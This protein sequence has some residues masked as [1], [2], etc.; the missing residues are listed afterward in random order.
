[1]MGKRILLAFLLLTSGCDIDT[2][3]PLAQF[4]GPA[5]VITGSVT[6][7]SPPPCT[8]NGEIVGAA[9]LFAFEERLLPPPEG[10]GTVPVALSVVS[11]E[12][13]FRSVRS[14]LAFD[15]NGARLCPP[16]G[17]P[18]VTVTA[19]YSLSPL[20]GGVYQIRGFYDYDGDFNPG[21]SM[22][23]LPT[24]GDV[25]GGAI[26]NPE[27]VLM[28]AAPRFRGVPLGD[29]DPDGVRRIPESG[30]L[31]E[32][33]PVTLGLPLPLER[34]IFH[35]SAVADATFGNTDPANIVVPSD[36]QLNV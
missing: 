36:Y 10:L 28:G 30:S 13:L 33:V 16:A 34:P 8:Q 15:P 18:S 11:G 3:V 7:A 12:L 19:D 14:Q 29:L 20:P 17:S 5:G 26:E 1:M 24:A 6:Y 4:G 22:F 25:G 31:V 23:N 21:F 2:F 32:G 27:A 35:V 9:V